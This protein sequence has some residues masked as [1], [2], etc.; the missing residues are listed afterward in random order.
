MTSKELLAATKEHFSSNL[1]HI[2]INQIPDGMIISFLERPYVTKN[3]KN[4]ERTFEMKMDM[5]T[6]YILS[7][8]LCD[9]TP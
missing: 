7:Q 8:S 2:A 3:L 1:S 9:V 6:D 5:L 4:A